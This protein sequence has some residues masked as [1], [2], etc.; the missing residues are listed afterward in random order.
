MFGLLG[1]LAVVGGARAKWTEILR[2]LV[3]CT[4]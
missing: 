2:E 1:P 3:V 4:W